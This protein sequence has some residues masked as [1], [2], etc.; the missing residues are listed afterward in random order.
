MYKS[1]KIAVV[2]PVHDE[3]KF[4]ANVVK[5]IPEL[6]DKIFIVDDKSTDNTVQVVNTLGN[7]K[8]EIILNDKNIGVGGSTIKGFE[9]AAADGEYDILIKVDGDG[10][11][12]CGDIP[13]FLDEIIE[14]KYDYVKG[15][16]FI[17]P[18]SLE[19][20]PLH[21]LFGNI[22]LTFLNKLASGYW[23]V[24]DPQCGFFAIDVSVYLKLDVHKIY[25]RYFFE[26]DM[27]IQLN[28]HNSRVK[29]IPI[30]T[31]YGNE[32][33]GISILAVLWSFPI[34][35]AKRF[36]YRVYQKYILRDFSPVAL[37]L[38]AGTVLCAF[39]SVFGAYKWIYGIITNTFT[40][41]GTVMI[42]VLPIVLGFQ[43]LLQAIVL[44][45]QNTPK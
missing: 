11:M 29:D 12:P 20:M 34:L 24:F 33:S 41:T 4:I 39:G 25:R 9:R 43:L 38:I 37:F 36:V 15:N 22:V 30:D 8:V 23:N 42:S 16:R 26:N 14:E 28:I 18:V 2:V 3:E 27:L 32:E 44:D 45:I 13:K 40:S 17:N 21:R 19:S 10:Q 1:K 35:F 6:A 5:Q 7:P 31:I